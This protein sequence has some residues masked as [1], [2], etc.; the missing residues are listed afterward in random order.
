MTKKIFLE[1]CMIFFIII[2]AF[3]SETQNTNYNIANNSE[4]I[5]LLASNNY[6]RPQSNAKSFRLSDEQILQLE[7]QLEF[8]HIDYII[9]RYF[10]TSIQDLGPIL[11]IRGNVTLEARDNYGNLINSNTVD[12]IQKIEK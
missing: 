2:L 12:F 8:D 11:L 10:I 6:Y 5:Y 9:K 7:Y 3:G 4:S 1:L